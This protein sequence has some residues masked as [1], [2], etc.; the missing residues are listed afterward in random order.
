MSKK[1][2]RDN[3]GVAFIVPTFE[4]QHYS[5]AEW[6]DKST[7]FLQEHIS[8]HYGTRCEK[9]AN[10]IE[11]EPHLSI[12]CA[13][14]GYKYCGL[15]LRSPGYSTGDTRMCGAEK[16]GFR[17]LDEYCWCKHNRVFLA[18]VLSGGEY[19]Y[20]FVN[21]NRDLTEEAIPKQGLGFVDAGSECIVVKK[22]N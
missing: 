20:G 17:C 19:K 1:R 6:K 22:M 16:E 2:K 21:C 7:K 11:L 15:P 14:V 3:G 4:H 13:I 18:P 10:R 5:K 8:E 9:D 12:I